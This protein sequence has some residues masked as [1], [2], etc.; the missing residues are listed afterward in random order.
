MVDKG[1]GLKEVLLVG[2]SGGKL[3]VRLCSWSNSKHVKIYLTPCHNV[4]TSSLNNISMFS[5]ARH[6]PFDH[7]I[8]YTGEAAG[9]GGGGGGKGLWGPTPPP[10]PPPPRPEREGTAPPSPM[11][12][13]SVRFLL[14]A[15]L[16]IDI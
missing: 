8:I 10:P 14:L 6:F 15:N 4:E 1:R 11:L 3:E 5:I 13:V 12:L 9:G 7:N 16:E 2:G